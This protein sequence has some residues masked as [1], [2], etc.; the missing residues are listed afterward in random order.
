M[1]MNGYAQDLRKTGCTFVDSLQ[2]KE[3]SEIWVL[4]FGCRFTMVH[5]G[6]GTEGDLGSDTAITV[7]P[8][9]H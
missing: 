6:L 2:R 8:E 3:C 1:Q 4:V 9:G 7:S 5:P